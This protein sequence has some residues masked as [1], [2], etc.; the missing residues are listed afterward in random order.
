MILL[1]TGNG[2]LS[3]GA[4]VVGPSTESSYSDLVASSHVPDLFVLDGVINPAVR[5]N[6]AYNTTLLPKLSHLPHV[7]GSPSTV[8]LNLGPLTPKG[9]PLPPSLS[10]AADASVNGLYFTRTQPP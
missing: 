1:V 4:F 5:L 8:E 3:M 10:I 9:T 7:D 2:G 6:S